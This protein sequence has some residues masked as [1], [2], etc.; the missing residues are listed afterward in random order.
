MAAKTA[1]E[2][3][4]LGALAEG[5]PVAVKVAGEGADAKATEV[6]VSDRQG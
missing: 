1:A 5:R 2:G 4:K 3:L 6:W